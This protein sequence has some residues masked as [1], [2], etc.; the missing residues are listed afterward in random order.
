MWRRANGTTGGYAVFVDSAGNGDGVVDHRDRTLWMSHYGMAKSAL[1]LVA[2]SELIAQNT[3]APDPAAQTPPINYSTAATAFSPKRIVPVI[4]NTNQSRATQDNALLAWLSDHSTQSPQTN[5]DNT[6][7][8]GAGITLEE[9]A[10]EPFDEV[11]AGL[12]T[13]C[14]HSG[15]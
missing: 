14:L 3:I 8:R 9:R 7:L 12:S 4:R 15:I 10:A 1:G 6:S 13:G 11:F 2:A 5:T